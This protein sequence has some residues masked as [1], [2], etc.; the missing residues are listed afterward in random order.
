MT[1]PPKL[2]SALRIAGVVAPNLMKL[3]TSVPTTSARFW[4][5]KAIAV[6]S[7]S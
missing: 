4:K 3:S 6:P 5:S 2:R 1:F 7:L